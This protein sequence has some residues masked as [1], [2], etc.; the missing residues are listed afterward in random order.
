M[1][2]KRCVSK[3]LARILLSAAMVFTPIVV[4][5]TMK[6]D[7]YAAEESTDDGTKEV[8]IEPSQES[9]SEDASEAATEPAPEVA[10]EIAPET[11][12]ETVPEA[13]Q[14]KGPGVCFQHPCRRQHSPVPLRC[15]IVSLGNPLDDGAGGLE[16]RKAADEIRQQSLCP[17]HTPDLITLAQAGL[18]KGRLRQDT[19]RKVLDRHR[20]AGLPG[21]GLPLHG[22]AV[23][24][25]IQ[26]RL[27]LRQS[28]IGVRGMVLVN[29][30]AQQAQVK[31][32]QQEN[33]RQLQS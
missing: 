2:R 3:E 33:D 9:T 23:V 21:D 8:A 1:R 25:Q 19:V 4:G 14:K 18:R 24:F 28:F 13:V 32:R 12:E 10:P 11:T 27:L 15:V 5:M 17:A 6:V 16:L 22:N 26:Q 29:H 30:D 20:K 31:D 7:S